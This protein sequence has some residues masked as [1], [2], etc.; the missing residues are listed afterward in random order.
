MKQLIDIIINKHGTNDPFAIAKSMG[1]IVIKEPL[2]TIRGYYSTSSRIKSIHINQDLSDYQQIFTAAHELG[3]AVLHP[4]SNTPFLRN[5][6]CFS[7]NKLEIQ[8]NTFAVHLLISDED[9]IEYQEYTTSQLSSI[10][11]LHENLIALRLK[12][13]TRLF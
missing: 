7:V 13:S 5:N 2:G 4:S 1:I 8:A 10:F 6:T 12:N 11:G 9:L 3:H